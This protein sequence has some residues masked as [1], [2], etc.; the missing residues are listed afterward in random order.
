M[1]AQLDTS[2]PK[3]LPIFSDVYSLISPEGFTNKKIL[4]FYWLRKMQQN[5][6][7]L[8]PLPWD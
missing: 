2:H 5:K 3:V 6:N 1:L 7:H 8:K 4:Q